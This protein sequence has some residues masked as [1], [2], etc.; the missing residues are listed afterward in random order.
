MADNPVA[1][2]EPEPSLNQIEETNLDEKMEVN[3]DEKE[4]EIANSDWP[5]KEENVVTVSSNLISS[6]NEK[7][8]SDDGRV[9]EAVSVESVGGRA[10]DGTTDVDIEN[11]VPKEDS[12]MSDESDEMFAQNVKIDETLAKNDDMHLAKNDEM[13]LAVEN[14][15]MNLAAE[16][17]GINLNAENDEILSAEKAKTYAED[18]INVDQTKTSGVEM[19]E[20]ELK[21]ETSS[22]ETVDF[23]KIEDSS[24]ENIETKPSNNHSVTVGSNLEL[25]G[26]PMDSKNTHV[27]MVE[28]DDVV[29]ESPLEDQSLENVDSKMIEDSSNE[30]IETKPSDNHSVTMGSIVER[31]GKPMD[32]KKTD[33]EM[34]EVDDAVKEPTPKMDKT[35]DQNLENV[36]CAEGNLK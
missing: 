1:S 30:N 29:K 12:E 4:V 23:E 6:E 16:N 35:E 7:H 5:N 9:E 26:E 25:L 36:D 31:L 20:A 32:S 18:T 8:L 24:N 15:Q 10:A 28:V 2:V 17:V 21:N 34:V 33:V 27:E 11:T 22:P 13:H 19:I 14:N 3:T